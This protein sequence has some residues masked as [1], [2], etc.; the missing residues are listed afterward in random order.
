MKRKVV[1]LCSSL[2]LSMCLAGCN[3]GSG[4]ASTPSASSEPVSSAEDVVDGV[5]VALTNT[6]L[7]VGG[8]FATL[9]YKVTV[10]HSVKGD[11]DLTGKAGITL[12]IKDPAN[13]EH[14]I[15]DPL[16]T[17]GTYSVTATYTKVTP[18]I[19]SSAASFSVAAGTLD[20]AEHFKKPTG[21]FENKDVYSLYSNEGDHILKSTGTQHLLVIPVDF[22][23]D[24]YTDPQLAK[25]NSAFF[26]NQDPAK[27]DV[28]WESL[29]SYYYKSSY[30]ALTLNGDVVSPYHSTM[31]STEAEKLTAETAG[32]T[33][34]DLTKYKDYW[35]LGWYI[36]DKAVADLKTRA[37]F[38]INDYDLDGDGYIDGLWMVYKHAYAAGTWW[39][40]THRDY[41]NMDKGVKDTNVLPYD[42]CWAS[43]NFIDNK[44]GD[45][46]P[47]YDDG[48]NVDCH[49]LT[50]ET[51]H[52]MGLNDYYDTDSKSSPMG[53]VAMMDLNIGD[54]DPYSKM[55]FNWITPR[56]IDD[57]SDYFQA[58]LQPFEETGDCLLIRDTTSTALTP[59]AKDNKNDEPNMKE[60]WNG[61]P[62]DEYILLAYTT[63]TGLNE[64]DSS[65][66]PE[67]L[68][69]TTRNGHAGTFAKGGIQ[70]WHVDSRL[71]KVRPGTSGKANETWVEYTDDFH[72]S[73]ATYNSDGTVMTGGSYITMRQSNTQSK[74][75][76]MSPDSVTG[77]EGSASSIDKG[78]DFR[79]VTLLT[80]DASNAFITSAYGSRT[81]KYDSNLFRPD[82]NFGFSKEK[83]NSYFKYNPSTTSTDV[84]F[85]DGTSIDYNFVVSGLTDSAAT[86]IFAKN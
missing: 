32:L 78:T 46:S 3:T 23:D 84:V 33:G 69:N 43:Y 35:N 7:K 15:Y 72:K 34:T 79:E 85:R 49:T 17:S 13:K 42:F 68:A 20:T 25:I 82:G 5:T 61:T 59:T 54:H 4:S 50:H 1:I 75:Y 65:G 21:T 6:N 55:L 37:C 19:V 83:F 40:F 39:A 53:G 56:V 80:S 22:T 28:S 67:W 30:G 86:L 47:Y 70:A 58:T 26:G 63:P 29:K 12:S 76:W 48:I 41:T 57:A 71:I 66:Y 9:G 16:L 38:N 60:A 27:K 52:L 8:T 11:F 36:A 31:T 81:G 10:H 74:T 51:G 18:N 2:F 44:L 64:K 14:G 77:G 62:F 73:T 45:G 24:Q